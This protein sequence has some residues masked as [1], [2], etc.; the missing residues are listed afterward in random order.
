M[1]SRSANSRRLE[2]SCRIRADPAFCSAG[3][4]SAILIG[5]STRSPRPRR[6]QV[7]DVAKQQRTAAILEQ[8]GDLVGVQSGVERHGGASGGDHAE[9]HGHPAGMVVGQDRDPCA[10]VEIRLCP[11]RTRPTPPCAAIRRRCSSQPDRGAGSPGRRFW[12]SARRTRQSDRK[13]WALVR[14]NI[15]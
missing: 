14:G 15:T 11:A 2:L 6:C 12:A 13:K 5:R 3:L 4:M 10:G 1:L 9:K 7:L 8:G